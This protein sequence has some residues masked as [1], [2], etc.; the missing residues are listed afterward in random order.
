[1]DETHG[2][3]NPCLERVY[4]NLQITPFAECDERERFV[5]SP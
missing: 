5:A 2:T 4:L 3:F 1:M